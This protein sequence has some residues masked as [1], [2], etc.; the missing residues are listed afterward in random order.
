MAVKIG[1]SAALGFFFGIGLSHLLNQP[2]NIFHGGWAAVTAILVIQARLGATY[3]AGWMRFLGMSIGCIIGYLCLEFLG[4][5]PLSLGLGTCF[6]SAVCAALNLQESMRIASIAVAIVT[7]FWEGSPDIAPLTFA[8]F[9]FIDACVGI[10]IAVIIAHVLWP[11]RAADKMQCN[12]AAI[13]KNMR[14]LL[15]IALT[16]DPLE[17]DVLITYEEQAKQ[18]LKLIEQSRIYVQ[19]SR[20]E[21]GIGPLFNDW[22]LLLE[23]LLDLYDAINSLYRVEKKHLKPLFSPQKIRE[24]TATSMQSIDFSMKKLTD[25]LLQG[26]SAGKTF[27]FLI[28]EE[29]IAQA[30]KEFQKREDAWK[31]PIEGVAHFVTFFYILKIVAAQV[32]KIDV[33]IHR[34]YTVHGGQKK[35]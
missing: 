3:F 35:T 29:K 14:Q 1:L 17:A 24:N 2:H 16:L 28:I 22:A 26:H 32:N 27:N 13:L 12:S 4:S 18:T 19:E 8:F 11:A 6:A 7:I 30:L 31:L 21:L 10:V 23:N 9:R 5:T 20:V 15:S 34:L 33:R 25:S